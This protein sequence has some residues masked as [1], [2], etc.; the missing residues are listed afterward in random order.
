VTE[1]EAETVDSLLDNEKFRGH[2]LEMIRSD[3]ATVANIETAD[4][5]PLILS[6]ERL[7]GLLPQLQHQEFLSIVDG[8]P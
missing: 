8:T 7:F 4:S 6:L 5:S 3:F 1:Q 2:V